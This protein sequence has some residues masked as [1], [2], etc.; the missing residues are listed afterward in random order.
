MN[1]TKCLIVLSLLLTS[2]L[3]GCFGGIEEFD[4]TQ[5]DEQITNLQKN[6]DEMNQTIIEHR[7]ANTELQLIIDLLNQQIEDYQSNISYLENKISYFSLHKFMLLLLKKP[8]LSQFYDL[9]PKNIDDIKSMVERTN[10][11]V[12]KFLKHN[13]RQN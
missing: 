9:K 6:Q 13:D 10:Q 12:E 1:R 8:I 7:L 2:T 5:L 11:Y 3:V 4:T